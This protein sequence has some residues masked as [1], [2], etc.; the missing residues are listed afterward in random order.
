VIDYESVLKRFIAHVLVDEGITFTGYNY[1]TEFTDEGERR[2][3]EIGE[4][5]MAEERA[6]AR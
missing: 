2:L 5:V 4:E 3:N 1:W 6:N